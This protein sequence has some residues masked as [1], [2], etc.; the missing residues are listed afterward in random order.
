[1]ALAGNLSL[2]LQ[3]D[4]GLL[5]PAPGPSCAASWADLVKAVFCFDCEGEGSCWERA[6]WEDLCWLLQKEP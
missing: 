6:E 1:M 5:R 4:I 3:R 2:D